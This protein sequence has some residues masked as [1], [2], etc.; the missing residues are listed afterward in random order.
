MGQQNDDWEDPD[1]D[2][3][4]DQGK[5]FADLRK[6]YNKLKADNKAL[7][8]EASVL[9]GSVRSRSVKDVLTS[10]GLNEAI[11]KFIPET[12]TS[13]DEVTAW[14]EENG[15]LFGA[16]ATQSTTQQTSTDPDETAAELARLQQIA[17]AQAGGSQYS[18][19]P[20]QLAARIEAAQTV[21]ELNT[22]LHGNPNG[23]VLAFT[24]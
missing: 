9:K 20:A 23:P 5:S 24:G 21:E 12:V 2:G 16:A 13:E 14:V 7:A 1:F 8:S 10:K 22:I 11:A 3:D 15:A 6:A 19:D 18:G 17:D 4:G